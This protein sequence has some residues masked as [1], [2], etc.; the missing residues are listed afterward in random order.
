M[1]NKFVF[2][3]VFL[4][5][6]QISN[7]Q[8]KRQQLK[9]MGTVFYQEDFK[10]ILDMCV[11]FQK[12]H[13]NE[14]DHLYYQ[15]IAEM[16]TFDRGGDI[17]R[18]L[19]FEA[20]K[21]KTD[22]FYNYWL[23]RIHLSRYE[24][25]DAREHL[26]AFLELD[27]YKSAIIMR[28]TRDML[29]TIDKA[30]PYYN[31]PDE[32]EVERLPE[33][34]NTIYSEISP[35]FFNGHEELIFASNRNP[36]D[37]H[38]EAEYYTIYHSEKKG[39]LWS[40]PAPLIVLGAFSY[41]N[42]KVEVLNN[43]NRL[44]FY[45]SKDGGN[46]MYSEY[47][48]NSWSLPREFDSKLKNR[49]VESHFFINDQENYVL[50][51][52]NKDIWETRLSNGEWTIPQRI[53]GKVNSIYEEESPFLS[54]SGN[55]LYFSS[56]RPS[57]MGGYDVYRSEFDSTRM[58]WKEAVNMGF[59]INTIDNDI[60][61]EVT[62]S[63]Q[64]GYLSSNRLH[65]V[66]EYDL[67]YFHKEDKIPVR[68]V[69]TDLNTGR[70]ARGVEVRFLPVVYEDEVFRNTTNEKGEFTV[71]VFNRE[72][73]ETEIRISGE[74]LYR[75][76]FESYI[77]TDKPDLNL[78]FEV[79]V[80]EHLKPKTNYA[81]LYQGAKEDSDVDLEM[82]GSKF[83]GGRK[84]VIN[85][86]YFDFQSAHIKSESWEVLSRIYVLM[87]KSP[88]LVVEIGGHTD[89]IGTHEYNMDL[90]QKRAESVRQYLISEG[91]S[92]DRLK[93]VGYG[94]LLPLASNDDEENGRELNRRIEI[95]VLE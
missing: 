40:D 26:Q 91:V 4:C 6:A 42:A 69:V 16:L 71:N 28:E 73:F 30:I 15:Y 54:H 65:S 66:G 74:T 59:P 19:E 22:K 72:K 55:I 76:E 21:G 44:Y 24:F 25:E 23:G 68:G 7:A 90:S 27:V 45:S 50:F 1:M 14:T 34:I 88:D 43:D 94:E 13:P 93:A 39:S 86:I 17:S 75:G 95:R 81:T 87:L 89:N 2:V 36:E 84:A 78:N 56:D 83:R 38:H 11:Q 9:K 32:Y 29:K 62:P 47:D 64:S 63:D 53:N 37:S 5:I 70:P 20:S 35:A 57:S 58:E 3:L 79:R 51:V 31:D 77:P 61:F 18:L 46:L 10:E 49:H 60:N 85:N 52:K 12:E 8:S 92:P 80:P 33:G 67:Y 82:L 41:E 48:K